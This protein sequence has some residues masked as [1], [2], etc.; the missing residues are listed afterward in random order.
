MVPAQGKVLDIGCGYGAFVKV[1]LEA[2]FDAY[3]V[4]LN[5]EHIHAGRSVLGLAQRLVLGSIEELS[6][7]FRQD[8]VFDLITLFEVIEHVEEPAVLIRNVLRLLKPGGIIAIS[9]PNEN[10]WQPTGRI[11]VDYPPHHLTRWRPDTMR[12]FLE[13]NGFVHVITEF[14]SSFRDLLWVTYSNRSAKKMITAVSP[15]P[16]VTENSKPVFG[17]QQEA[18]PSTKWTIKTNLDR[19]VR[20]ACAPIDIVL[21]ALH[22]G[23]MGMRVIARKPNT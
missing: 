21:K 14:D 3:G 8:E 4:D 18:H 11:F 13:R 7:K 9:C 1:A 17:G 12:A 2:G 16:E 15:H 6:E 19:L 10:R 20:V 23:T 5:P 22:V